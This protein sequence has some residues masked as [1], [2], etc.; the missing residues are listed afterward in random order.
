[1]KIQSLHIKNFK[2]IVDLT[3]TD[4]NPFTVFVGPN[5]AGKSNIFEALEYRLFSYKFGDLYRDMTNLFPNVYSYNAVEKK[6][7]LLVGSPR[8]EVR[9]NSFKILDIGLWSMRGGERQGDND[10]YNFRSDSNYYQFVDNHSEIFIANSNREKVSLKGDNKLS[11]SCDNLEKV[12]K[13]VLQDQNK[14]EEIKEWLALL[15]PGFADIDIVSSELSSTDT[16]VMYEEGTKKPFTKDLL[17]DGTYNIL[18]LLTAVYQSDEPQFLCIEEPENGL[19]P[20]VVRKLVDFFRAACQE[21]GHY[22]WLNTHSHDLVACLEPDEV[23]VVDKIGGET[24]VK[25]IKSMNLHGLDMAEV[26]LSG[27]LGGGTPW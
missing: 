13:R 9:F 1:V 23:V 26:W 14:R 21:R 8:I 18:A 17:S 25:Q 24:Q 3:L 2:S 11:T 22:I 5:G 12:L 4:P 19:N 20:Y 27:A 10:F 6:D 15:I 16:L 7:D